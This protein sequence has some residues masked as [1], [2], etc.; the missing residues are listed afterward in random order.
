MLM[1]QVTAGTSCVRFRPALRLGSRRS[2]NGRPSK[3]PPR[4]L[5]WQD[6]EVCMRVRACVSRR[7]SYEQNSAAASAVG[8]RMARFVTCFPGLAC[9]ANLPSCQ[10]RGATAL[11]CKSVLLEVT[12]PFVH[13]R[14]FCMGRWAWRRACKQV[15]VEQDILKDSRETLTSTRRAAPPN[16][17]MFILHIQAH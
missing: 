6:L 11:A 9:S 17:Q 16:T 14:V 7:A 1:L 4:Q 15:V 5:Q 3:R 13:V 12:L 2:A 8:I 10:C